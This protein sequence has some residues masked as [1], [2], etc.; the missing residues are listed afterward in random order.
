[1]W[2][3]AEAAALE[4][5]CTFVVVVVVGVLFWILTFFAQGIFSNAP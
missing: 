3:M 5:G 1:M 2:A 4:E